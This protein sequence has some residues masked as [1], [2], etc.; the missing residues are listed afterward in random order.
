MRAFSLVVAL[1]ALRGS[2]VAALTH[3]LAAFPMTLPSGQTI[4]HK[5]HAGGR[6][7]FSFKPT[8]S[9]RLN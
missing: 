6:P 7:D 3:A 5:S 9:A 8:P 4:G 1:A 2:L